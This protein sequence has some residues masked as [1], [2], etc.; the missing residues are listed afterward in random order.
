MG[1]ATS[2][3]RDAAM[4]GMVKGAVSDLVENFLPHKK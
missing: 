1:F 3:P 2:T 4:V